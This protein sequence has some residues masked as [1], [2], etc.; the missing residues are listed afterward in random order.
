MSIQFHCEHCGRPIEVGDHFEG[1]R[2]HCKHCGHPIA[3]PEHVAAGEGMLRLKPTEEEE[4]AGVHDHLLEA[5]APLNVRHAEAEPRPEPKSIS[6]PDTEPLA[7]GDEYAT[8]GPTVRVRRSSAGPPPFWVNIPTLT[9]RSLA[10]VFRTLRDWGYMVSLAA[11]TLALIG[12]SFKLKGALHVGVVIAIVANIEML[13]VGVAY[14]VTLPFKES[15]HHGLAN[16]IPPYAI[17]YWYSRW[18]KMKV[19]VR[20]TIGAFLPIALAGLAYFLYEDAGKVEKVVEEKARALE[21]RVERGVGE[22]EKKAPGLGTS[23]DRVLESGEPGAET[24]KGRVR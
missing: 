16:L 19:P 2:G 5:H 21:G 14:L 15:L 3:V 23:I 7:P 10:R 22:V 13:V 11:L 4:P 9:A 20:K 24:A 17:Y 6:D 8:G 1:K 12:F 18:P